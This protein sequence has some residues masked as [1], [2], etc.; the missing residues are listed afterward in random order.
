[1]WGM[2]EPQVGP[3][4][5]EEDMALDIKIGAK[6]NWKYNWSIEDVPATHCFGE[7]RPLEVIAYRGPLRG[8]YCP[9]HT[10]ML[11]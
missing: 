7:V 4:P 9:F 2:C 11:W 5:S 3:P 10:K 8:D 1:M 6:Y